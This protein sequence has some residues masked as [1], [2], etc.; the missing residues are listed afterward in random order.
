MNKVLVFKT[1][2]GY[3]DNPIM[4]NKP[5]LSRFSSTETITLI[6]DLNIKN[7][8]YDMQWRVCFGHSINGLPIPYNLMLKTPAITFDVVHQL[9][10]DYG[11]CQHHIDKFDAMT[12]VIE[13]FVSRY[14]ISTLAIE[15]YYLQ[16][17]EEK[18]LL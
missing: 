11:A 14:C 13:N 18:P 3:L 6:N 10:K 5:L 7:F 8:I 2:L 4:D 17:P 15:N 16:N 9:E 1:V 12:D